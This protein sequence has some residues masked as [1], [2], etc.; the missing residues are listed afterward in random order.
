MGM[1]RGAGEGWKVGAPEGMISLLVSGEGRL[2]SPVGGRMDASSKASP[3]MGLKVRPV[4][5]L[6]RSI[7]VE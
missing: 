3:R 7:P 6:R 1:R 5:E 2:G 4:E